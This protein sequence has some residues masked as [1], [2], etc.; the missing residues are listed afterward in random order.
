MPALI[1]SAG[2]GITLIILYSKLQPFEGC[3][4]LNVY[5]STPYFFLGAWAAPF[6]LVIK[7]LFVGLGRSI[8][9]K[10]VPSVLGI[11]PSACSFG[12]YPRP[13]A[14]FFL[15]WVSRL[16]NNL[17]VLHVRK[18][19]SEILSWVKFSFFFFHAFI[20]LRCDNWSHSSEMDK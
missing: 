3:I 12:R 6:L 14:Q 4:F 13:Q 20:Y 1:M 5:E 15:I 19:L 8:P 11:P 2:I 16:V 7:M 17:Y 10:T 9:A 18:G